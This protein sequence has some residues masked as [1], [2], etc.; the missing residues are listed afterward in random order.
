MIIRPST[1]VQQLEE[2]S[3]INK[4]VFCLT[5]VNFSVFYSLLWQIQDITVNHEPSIIPVSALG[6]VM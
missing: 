2:S 4:L 5:E 3:T 1:K 6:D